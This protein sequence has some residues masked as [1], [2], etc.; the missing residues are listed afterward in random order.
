[1]SVWHV[2]AHDLATGEE[3]CLELCEGD[4]IPDGVQLPPPFAIQC[5]K[6]GKWAPP[7]APPRLTD[8]NCEKPWIVGDRSEQIRDGHRYITEERLHR[9]SGQVTTVSW[10]EDL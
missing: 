3:V 5:V 10:S 9:P 1:M 8:P 7:P 6:D 4:P 2:P